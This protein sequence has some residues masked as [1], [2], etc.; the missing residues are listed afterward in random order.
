MKQRQLEQAA[1]ASAYEWA[2]KR[3][4]HAAD[5]CAECANDLPQR[6]QLDQDAETLP[7]PRRRPR[8][9]A[10]TAATRRA[11]ARLVPEVVEARP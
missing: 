3:G 4:A 10:G 2:V 9:Y 11:L 6:A 7:P 5:G 1:A 8:A